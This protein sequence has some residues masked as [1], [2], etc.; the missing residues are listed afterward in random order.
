L[1]LLIK[2][3]RWNF[4]N[5]SMGMASAIQFVGADRKRD[6]GGLNLED[7]GSVVKTSNLYFED[8]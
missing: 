7:Y 2:D 3:G 1:L 5:G 6:F 8:L 4:V